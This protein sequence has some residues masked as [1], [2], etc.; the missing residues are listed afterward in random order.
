MH[1]CVKDVSTDAGCVSGDVASKANGWTADLVVKERGRPQGGP[2][3]P[4]RPDALGQT[5]PKPD[6]Q[7]R[8]D[9]A[10]EDPEPS[11]HICMQMLHFICFACYVATYVSTRKTGICGRELCKQIATQV[12]TVL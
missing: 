7:K 2:A 11:S 12:G 8:I 10:G 3:E 6:G 9:G 5:E 4:P 1:T